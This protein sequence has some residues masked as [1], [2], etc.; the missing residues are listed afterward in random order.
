ML[1]FS[2]SSTAWARFWGRPVCSR[3]S[4]APDASLGGGVHR[5]E[6]CV[7]PRFRCVS[8]GG[9]TVEAGCVSGRLVVVVVVVKGMHAVSGK[10]Q[11]AADT[12]AHL[13][14]LC[15]L[16]GGGWGGA[17]GGGGGGVGARPPPP[18]PHTHTHTHPH[19]CKA[20]S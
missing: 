5:G 12:S 11:A 8:H 13:N 15:V 10:V 1:A 4:S 3:R 2:T 18:P 14:L 9:E 17:W 7:A 6:M 16:G 20:C 19:T